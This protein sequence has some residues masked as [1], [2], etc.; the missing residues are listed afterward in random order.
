MKRPPLKSYVITTKH[1]DQI[2]KGRIVYWSKD[3]QVILEEPFY[4]E[5]KMTHMMYM[6]PAR[7]VTPEDTHDYSPNI[8]NIDIVEKCVKIMINLYEENK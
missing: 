6:I 4:K 3:Y 7:F 5:T 8:H 2:L 1:N